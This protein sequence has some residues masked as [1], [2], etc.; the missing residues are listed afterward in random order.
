M[1][2]LSEVRHLTL[3]G[4]TVA[5]SEWF[6]GDGSYSAEYE[7]RH[8]R[9]DVLTRLEITGIEPAIQSIA[10]SFAKDR[11]A[12]QAA[13]KPCSRVDLD[14]QRPYGVKTEP[15][16]KVLEVVSYACRSAV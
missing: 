4:N 1:S 10:F 8:L 15:L 2:E 12:R 14:C 3:P 7:G 5:H 16:D 13:L 9:S 6:I 11:T